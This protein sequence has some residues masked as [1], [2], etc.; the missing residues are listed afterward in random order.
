MKFELSYQI[1]KGFAV[2]NCKTT[3]TCVP[4]VCKQQKCV[5]LYDI[6]NVGLFGVPLRSTLALGN[7]FS[8]VCAFWCEG[9]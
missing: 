1:V 9:I 8:L 5:E 4:V 3:F 6:G 2:H 7:N